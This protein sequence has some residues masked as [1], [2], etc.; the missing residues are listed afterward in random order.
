MTRPV[1]L[2][3][4][5]LRRIAADLPDPQPATWRGRAADEAVLLVELCRRAEVCSHGGS[6]ADPDVGQFAAL[7]ADMALRGAPLRAVRWFLR[8]A[9]AHVFA[10]LWDSSGAG[11]ATLLLRVSRLL[12]RHRG[13]LDQVLEHTYRDLAD[14]PG[15][16]MPLLAGLTGDAGDAGDAGDG[17]AYL[18]V[19]LAGPI[20]APEGLPPATATA[21][22]QGRPHLVVP[23]GAGEPREGAW[24]EVA[25]WAAARGGLR[26]AGA[27]ADGP[28]QVASA[29]AAARRLLA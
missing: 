11:D 27:F 29:A 19:V 7:F 24:A 20:G 14:H 17:T 16:A 23:I 18:V 9:A 21:T 3:A 25:R 6:D 28:G 22:V 10:G 5:V 4:A 26:A 8:S 1:A 2:V 15:A 12:N 13:A